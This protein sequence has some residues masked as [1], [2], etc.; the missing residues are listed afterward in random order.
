MNFCLKLNKQ[1]DFSQQP[2]LQFS[3]RKDHDAVVMIPHENGLSWILGDPVYPKGKRGHLDNLLG[4]GQFG[5]FLEHV[6]G[7]YYLLNWNN[8]AGKLTVSSSMFNMLPVY[9]CKLREELF[10][11]SSFDILRKIEGI[12]FTIDKQYLLEKSLFHYP[13]FTRTA[14][15]QIKTIPSN[16]LLVY[17]GELTFLRHTSIENYFTDTPIP[18]RKSLDHLS[19]LFLECVEAFFPSEPFCATLTGGFDGR[20]VVATALHQQHDFF[21]YSYGDPNTKDVQIPQLISRKMG[22]QHKS[23]PLNLQ[24]TEKHFWKHGRSF[25]TKSFG[26]GN[27][28]RA[29]YHFALTSVLNKSRYLLSGNFG[30]EIIRCM[31]IPGVMTSASLFKIFTPHTLE[32]LKTEL[33]NHPG[34]KYL[35]PD[36]LHNCIDNLLEDIA[37]YLNRLPKELSDNKRFYIYL[38]EEVFPKYF[39]PEI[40]VQ[41]NHLNHRAPFLCV[42]FIKELL[43]TEIAGANSN[44]METNPFNRYHG[45][46]LYAHIFKKSSPELLDF[47]LDRGYRPAHFL[48]PMGPLK[49]AAGYALR[50]LNKSRSTNIPD[51]TREN[52]HRNIQKLSSLNIPESLFNA[53]HFKDQLTGNWTS[54]QMNFINMTSALLHQNH[55]NELQFNAA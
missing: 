53:A 14:F 20:T 46:V 2:D 36:L 33:I 18:W 27:I 10:I 4:T 52:I 6:D 13:L 1:S 50:K 40:L 5:S 51:Y 11:S 8:E 34:A 32:S 16:H 48:T 41:K 38:F 22:F 28:S 25:L 9:Y 3:D 47:P 7:F 44:F 29:H 21:T 39:G 26:L 35:A 37:H 24:Y 45:Q 17:N 54:D 43:K 23:L 30:S 31:K 19:D 42:R 15:E 49:I 55:I 12:T